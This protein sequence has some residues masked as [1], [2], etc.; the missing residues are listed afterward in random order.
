M[1]I[2]LVLDVII[3]FLG[4]YMLFQAF[5]MKKKGEISPVIITQEEI[6]KCKDKNGF[7]QN[8][9][10]KEAVFGG[11][12]VFAGVLGVINEQIFKAGAIKYVVGAIFLFAFFWFQ[13]ALGKARGKFFY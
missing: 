4:I 10:K 5:G 7:I 11:I 3:I 6:V 13:S 12:I 1:N 8:I 9:Y 2:M